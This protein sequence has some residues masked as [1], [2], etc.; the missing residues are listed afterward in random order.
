MSSP[1]FYT[2]FTTLGLQ[3]LAEAQMSGVPLIFAR[4][5]VGDG[6]G[7]P[8]TPAS[9]MTALVRERTRVVV[10]NV[11]ISPDASTTVRVEG[12][13]PSDVGGFTIREV[14][15]FNGAGELIAVASHPD[16]YKPAPS[17]GVTADVYIR[18]LLV[19][20]AVTA[21]ALTTDPH[22][23]M[24]TRLYVDDRTA[25]GLWLWENYQ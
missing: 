18:L 2:I 7:S 13:I 17:D 12:L 1:A 23:I 25:G 14:G 24:A 16:T 22:V 10:N 4:L 19:Y 11:E 6:G 5:A 21:I 8:I 9:S 3:R 20:A 15:L